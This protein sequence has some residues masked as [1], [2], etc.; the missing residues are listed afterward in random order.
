MKRYIKWVIILLVIIP[1]VLAGTWTAKVMDLSIFLFETNYTFM[2]PYLYESPTAVVNFNE[3]KLNQT[4]DARANGGGQTFD[5]ILNTS[6]NVTFRTVNVTQ[7][8][9]I[10]GNITGNTARSGNLVVNGKV[11]IG[12]NR[13]DE[14][15]DLLIN[16]SWAGHSTVGLFSGQPN[17][18]MFYGGSTTALFL[19]QLRFQLDGQSGAGVIGVLLNSNPSYPVHVNASGFFGGVFVEDK[20]GT[21]PAYLYSSYVAQAGGSLTNKTAF[22]FWDDSVA[23]WQLRGVNINHAANTADLE[24]THG[25]I[26]P[27]AI[28]TFK[29]NGDVKLADNLVY[30]NRTG[31]FV[32]I[33]G[34]VNIRTAD[35]ITNALNIVGTFDGDDVAINIKNLANNGYVTINFQN[36]THRLGDF[37]YDQTERSFLFDNV[38]GSLI[39]FRTDSYQTRLEVSGAN[40]KIPSGNLSVNKNISAQTYF[41]NM[42]QLQAISAAPIGIN[43]GAIYADSDSKELCYYNGT[44]WT[45]LVYGGACI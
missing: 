32:N 30:M 1:V 28:A 38:Y 19:K 36:F 39:R 29:S 18:F 4:I 43:Q 41:G 15:Y 3:T 45:G 24:I 16:S 21:T 42:L 34:Q 35:E 12:Q 5:Q 9:T 25:A 6:S 20:A 8:L 13:S 10:I 27:Q 26:T 2:P 22:S 11:T 33:S 17:A 40:I 37:A 31:A 7:N 23:T 14:N 44:A